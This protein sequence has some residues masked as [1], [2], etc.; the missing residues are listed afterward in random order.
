MQTLTQ[1]FKNAT[2]FIKNTPANEDALVELAGMIP[3]LRPLVENVIDM[4][5]PLTRSGHAL[6]KHAEAFNFLRNHLDMFDPMDLPSDA[7]KTFAG[8][9]TLVRKPATGDFLLTMPVSGNDYDRNYMLYSVLPIVM[10]ALFNEQQ[11]APMFYE[12]F[13]RD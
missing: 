9:L 2:I 4:D 5:A 1:T 6:T 8:E 7:P 10:T 11:D 13:R 3:A 12:F